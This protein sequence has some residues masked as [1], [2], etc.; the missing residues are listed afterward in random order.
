[1]LKRKHLEKKVFFLWENPYIVVFICHIN[2][3]L[4]TQPYGFA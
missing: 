3:N 4:Y 2:F 1:M